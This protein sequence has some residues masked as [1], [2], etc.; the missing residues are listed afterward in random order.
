MKRF[1]IC[2][3][4][5]DQFVRM[6]MI[7]YCTVFFGNYE[8]QIPVMASGECLRRLKTSNISSAISVYFLIVFQS[9][10]PLPD[11]NSCFL[12]AR[13]QDSEKVSTLVFCES[14]F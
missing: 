14:G 9:A 3:Q 4:T 2:I 5:P 12:W 6:I 1:I 7:C 10:R 11:P 13:T 8:S